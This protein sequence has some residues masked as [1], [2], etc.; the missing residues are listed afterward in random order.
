MPSLVLIDGW[1]GQLHAAAD[2]LEELGITQQAMASIAKKEEILYVLGQEDEPMVL[3]RR[4]PVLRL[5]QMVRDE[6]HRFAVTYHRKRREMRDR[7]SEL[8]EIE[9]VGARTRARLLEH[10][11]SLRDVKAA[12]MDA[13]TAVVNASVAVKIRAHFD[14]GSKAKLSSELKIL[15]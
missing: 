10:F 3:E 2:A 6:S 1:L 15:Q 9:G 11:G 14:G 4:S 7:E 13:L 8:L 5:I 12:S